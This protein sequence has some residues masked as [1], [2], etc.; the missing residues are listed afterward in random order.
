MPFFFVWSLKKNTTYGKHEYESKILIYSPLKF[1]FKALL[2]QTNI[3]NLWV[4]L[5]ICRDTDSS[6]K[7]YV[8]CS[9]LSVLSNFIR[10]SNN[11]FHDKSV[12]LFSSHYLDRWLTADRHIFATFHWTYSKG[13]FTSSI[14]EHRC[15][16]HTIFYWTSDFGIKIQN[17]NLNRMKINLKLSAHLHFERYAHRG[18]DNTKMGL[19]GIEEMMWIGLIWPKTG[20]S[21]GH[22]WT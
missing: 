3:K 1:L 9:D 10:F 2:I 20:S 12:K 8:L 6:H 16:L 5:Q 15:T 11:K 17:S 21:R 22:L 13:Q 14:M 7:V 4:M 18:D 19:K